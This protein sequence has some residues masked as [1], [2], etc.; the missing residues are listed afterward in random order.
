MK[1]LLI[2]HIAD[3]DGVSPICLLN[4]TKTKFD[5]ELKEINEIDDFMAKLL[6]TDLSIYRHI[7]ITDLSLSEKTYEMIN[8]SAFKYKFKVFDHHKTHLFATKYDYVTIDINEC[9]TTLFYKYLLKRKK[10][11]KSVKE[12]VEHIKN[13]DL[14]LW[15]EKKDFIAKDLNDLFEI[16]GRNKYIEEITKKL[17]KHRFK[18]NNFEKQILLLEQ[19]KIDRY[20]KKKEED[21]ILIKY[22][23]LIGGLVFCEKYKSELGNT[24]CLN[25]PEIDYLIMIN[26][27]GGISFRCSKDLDISEIAIKLGGGGHK[28]ACGAPI[29]N[30]ERIKIIKDIFKGC[31]IIDK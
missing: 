18:I 5:Y 15:Q 10:F 24:L 21:M 2:S 27:A 26:I 8:N 20:I 29:S 1:D 6:D 3:P 31:E 9:A 22:E 23:G 16:Y 19:D 28:K 11:K 30:E 25:H 7:Y 17:K 14:W 13:I 4:L 12:Y